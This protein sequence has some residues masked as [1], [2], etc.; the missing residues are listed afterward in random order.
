M[1][2]QKPAGDADLWFVTTDG[3]AKL[4]DLSHDPHVNL[5]YYRD[6]NGEWIPVSGVATVSRDRAKI[7]ELYSSDWKAWFP[8]E[9]DPRHGTDFG[10]MHHLD[11]PG[12]P[13]A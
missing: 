10:E 4:A 5:S 6:S 8:D 9:G 1:A 11:E 3:T 13:D 7:R 2:N 12:G